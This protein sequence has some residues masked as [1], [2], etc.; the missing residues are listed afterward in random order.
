MIRARK[1]VITVVT[2]LLSR[3]ADSFDSDAVPLTFDLFSATNVV[4]TSVVADNKVDIIDHP[5]KSQTRQNL[6][7]TEYAE[8]SRGKP[9]NQCDFV[10]PNTVWLTCVIPGPP[11]VG[12]HS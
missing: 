11:V 9:G 1:K 2:G 8:Y 3:W 4:F 7:F 12:T 6:L 5:G 10:A